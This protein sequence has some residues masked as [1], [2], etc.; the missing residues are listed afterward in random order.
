MHKQDLEKLKE[1]DIYS[2][3]LFALYK[4]HEIPEYSSLSELAYALDKNSLLNL[5]E[6]FGGQTITIPTVEELE[7][8]TYSL[9]LYQL[10]AIENIDYEDALNTLRDRCHNLRKV[11][12]DYRKLVEVMKQY[13]FKPYNQ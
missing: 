13:D 3:I 2:L 5:C 7:S 1:T 6:L 10:T 12:A 4:M 9:V 8:I 11:A